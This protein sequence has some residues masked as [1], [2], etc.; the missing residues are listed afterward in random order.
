MNRQTHEL[1]LLCLLAVLGTM[2]ASMR[3]DLT[4]MAVFL[5][6]AAIAFASLLRRVI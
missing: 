5:A 2:L 4:F 6:Q 3:E 1:T